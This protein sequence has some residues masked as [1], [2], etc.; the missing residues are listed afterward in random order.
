M[1]VAECFV[2]ARQHQASPSHASLLAAEGSQVPG[3]TMGD[4]VQA[5]TA[6]LLHGALDRPLLPVTPKR[7]AVMVQ[8]SRQ[9]EQSVRTACC[10]GRAGARLA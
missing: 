9:G 2:G 5:A 10:Q 6:L 8:A 1:F 3:I 4:A 7:M